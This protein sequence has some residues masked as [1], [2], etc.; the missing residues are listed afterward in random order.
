M[1]RIGKQPVVV[2]SGVKVALAD[3]QVAIEGPQGKLA[4]KYRPELNLKYD[5]QAKQIVISRSDDGRQ[6]RRCTV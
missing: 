3:G 1:S 2:P 6:S 4:W 5:E